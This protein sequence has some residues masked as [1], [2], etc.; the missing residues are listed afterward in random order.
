MKLGRDV[1]TVTLVISIGLRRSSAPD[2]WK[3]ASATSRPLTT[4]PKIA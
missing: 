2:A 1:A 3:I 4:F